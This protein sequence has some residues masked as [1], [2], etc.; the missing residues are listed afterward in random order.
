MKSKPVQIAIIVIGLL[1]GAFGIF[2]AMSGNAGPDLSD[3]MMMVDVTT[4]ETFAVSTKGRS[5]VIP[6]KNPDTEQFTLLPMIQNEEGGD[7]YV[8][9]RY[10]VALDE[11]E[12]KTDKLDQDSG[13]LSIDPDVKPRKIN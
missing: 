3:R 12:N 4:G 5:I 13:K 9:S 10:M 7:W 1:V 2:L 8:K 6:Y 11:I